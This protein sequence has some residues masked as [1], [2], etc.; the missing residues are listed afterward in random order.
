[1]LLAGLP[2]FSTGLGGLAALRFRSRLHVLLG[3]S[4]GTV[5]GAVFFDLLPAVFEQGKPSPVLMIPAA[6]GFLAFHALERHAGGHQGRG[7]P[8]HEKQVSSGFGLWAAAGLS[9]HSF[10]D[11]LAIGVGF[12]ARSSLGVLIA[13]AVIAHDFT[14]GLNTVTVVL[15]HKNPVRRAIAWL[16]VD[17]IAPV[18]GAAMSVLLRPPASVLPGLLAFF[19][20]TFLYLGASDLLP[21]A[22]ED[23]S[24]W[25]WLT[26]AVGLLA[27]LVVSLLLRS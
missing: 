25:I 24:P 19:C 3:L 8:D 14:D 6:V 7:H 17:M 5:L 20:G 13:L 16:L 12:Q 22:R 27:L 26:T 4:S 9:L 11:G 23:A 1:V 18:L 10:I 15:A 21:E 2:F